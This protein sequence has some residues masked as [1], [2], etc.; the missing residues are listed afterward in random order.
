MKILLAVDGSKNSLAAVDA[1]IEHADWYR[2]APQVE[3]ITV[4]L[5]VPKLPGMGAAVG[6]KQ[7]A[8]YYQ[9]EGEQKLAAARRKLDAARVKYQARVLV[10]PVAETLV[11]HATRERCDLI[12]IGTRGMS[13]LGKA[14][15]GSTATK[16]MHISPLP[17]LLV[18]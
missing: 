11:K 1:L 12:F 15:L 3:L 8:D 5:P 9:Q 16:V 17:V 2:E 6:K 13:E 18:K 7:I 10:G 14:L 4:H